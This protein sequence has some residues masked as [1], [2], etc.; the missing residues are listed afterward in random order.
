METV[1][2]FCVKTIVAYP[3]GPVEEHKHYFM[4]RT[5]ADAQQIKET[6]P[7]PKRAWTR[8]SRATVEPALL[9]KINGRYYPL[10]DPV[11]VC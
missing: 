2:A 7:D 4:K 11:V 9:L 10:P 5:D 8:H 1:E 3:T 6:T